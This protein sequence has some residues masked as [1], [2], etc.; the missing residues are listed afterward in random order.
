MPSP[1]G[2]ALAGMAAGI[3]LAAEPSSSP[4]GPRRSTTTSGTVRLASDALFFGLLGM[5]PD[6]DLLVG[7]H[8][9]E[10]HSLGAACAVSLVAASL[11]PTD[12]ARR[13]LAC[14]AAYASHI[15]LDW[16]GSDT[17]PPIGIMA[18][19]PWSR[20]FFQSSAFVFPAVSREWASP[21]FWPAI[22]AALVREAML[23]APLALIV[24]WR[25]RRR[26]VA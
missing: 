1:F 19:W 5:A 26:Y 15:L 23:L 6:L 22:E 12:R 16:L 4:D 9:Q 24:L 18:L 3:A 10:T 7:R 25:R 11:R 8:S 14:G 13:A 21:G 2:H 20:R 17:T